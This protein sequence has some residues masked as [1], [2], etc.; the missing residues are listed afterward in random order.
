[1]SDR[2]W[3]DPCG[4]WHDPPISIEHP[5]RAAMEASMGRTL[6]RMGL[7]DDDIGALARQARELGVR[8]DAEPGMSHCLDPSTI[9]QQ[10]D[11][12]W[13]DVHPEDYC[14]RCGA[15]NLSWHVDSDR[16]N[17]AMKSLGLTSGAIVCPSC[18]VEGH[19]AATGLRASWEVRPS[20]PF[21]H[22]ADD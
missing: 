1:M 13:P 10:R 8:D 11:R 5:A 2:I 15:H 18:F 6:S 14:H 17:A 21:R 9:Q 16:F 22:A 20:T 12:G 7:E 4:Q 3:C 19:E